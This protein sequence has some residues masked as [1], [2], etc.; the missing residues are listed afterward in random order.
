MRI[1]D[2]F[3]TFP[4]YRHDVI[5][6][7]AKGES[8]VVRSTTSGTH[9]GVGKLKVNGGM[10]DQN[11]AEIRSGYWIFTTC[12]RKTRALSQDT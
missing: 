4:D 6:M 9:R 8:V 10:L 3:T 5:E 11:F 1:E 2:I 7:I 12:V